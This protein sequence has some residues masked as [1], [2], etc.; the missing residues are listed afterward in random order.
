MISISDTAYPSLKARISHQDLLSCY[1]PTKDELDLALSETRT[2]ATQF[3]FL[4]TLKTLQHLGYVVLTK[5]IPD[6]II[7]HVCFLIGLDKRKIIFEEYD[8]STVRAIH[9]KI[10]FKFLNI[11]NYREGGKEVLQK[12]AWLAASTR[13]DLPSIV[14]A[15]LDTLIRKRFELP[16]FSSIVREAQKQRTAYYKEL[17]NTIFKSLDAHGKDSLAALFSISSPHKRSAW[18]ELKFE[19]PSPKPKAIRKLAK[20]IE[21]LSKWEEFDKILLGIPAVKLNQLAVEARALDVSGIRE[22]EEK[23]RFSLALVLVSN[24]R[25]RSLDTLIDLFLK[26]MSVIFHKS[27]A[28]LDK[29]LRENQD[30][31][32]AIL[33]K[34]IEVGDLL[35]GKEDPSSLV[36]TIK[37]IVNADEGLREYA[38]TH[39]E[40]G[41][42]HHI[43][44]MARSFSKKRGLIFRIL[45]TLEIQSG[46]HDN[47]LVHALD[48]LKS[49][50]R[51]RSQLIET[52][53]TKRARGQN[54]SPICDLSWVPDRWWKLITGDRN[55]THFPSH[56]H[57][58]HFEAC[59]CDQIAFAFRTGDLFVSG[60]D[61]YD[62]Y[63]KEL[64]P[65]TECE[66]TLSAYGE[67]VGLPVEGEMFVAFVKKSLMSKAQSTDDKKPENKSFTIKSGEA[68]LKPLGPR[69]RQQRNDEDDLLHERMS[70]HK[71]VDILTDTAQWLSWH[72]AF[73]PHSGHEGKIKDEMKRY[74][75]TVFA[76]G[77]GLGPT[78]G[79]R[80]LYDFTIH[81]LT[82]TDKHHISCDKLDRA[83][84]VV[85]AA[86]NKLALPRIW[87]EGKHVAAD[88]TH[89]S[90]TEH[91]A[92]GEK[93][94]RYGEWGAIAYYH[95]SDN[96]IAI[97][98]KFI[99]CGVHEAVYILDA[100]MAQECGSRPEF[101]HGDTHAQSAA[102]YGLSYLLGIKLMPRI[103][104]WQDLKM[105]K[106]SPELIY[107]H[108]E[109]LFSDEKP[110]W[111]LVNRHLPDMYQVAQSI[112]A[113]RIKPSTI[114]R[115]LGTANAKNKLF[116]A[117][118]ALGRI[119][120][121][122]YLL[123]YISDT[124][125]RHLIQTT[126]NRCE[127]FHKF[128]RWIH[129]AQDFIK[130]NKHDEQIKI[131]KYNHLIATLLTFHNAYAMTESLVGME[132]EGIVLPPEEV[133]SLSP[134]RT[135]H[136]QRFGEFKIEANEPKPMDFCLSPKIAE[137]LVKNQT[138]H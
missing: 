128:A 64:I 20:H 43:R 46:T 42:K 127:Q 18:D 44:F 2:L 124:E 57:R 60:S 113:G 86:Y 119:V 77:T 111:E 13:E 98:S 34:F 110:N 39:G 130:K 97:F 104:S 88:G 52:A 132:A 99:A 75:A 135:K 118:N 32:D 36:D 117:F 10:I 82:H 38:R 89:W 8:D 107:A 73:G 90:L 138:M 15:C 48:F 81:Q 102:A 25:G 103:R 16:A 125:L 21:W 120:R 87:G 17:Y 131:I 53:Q 95:V 83:I 51:S 84:S 133:S 96:Y 40:F 115:R 134:F 70:E 78:E 112:M 41:G 56:V 106:A 14:N 22:V 105:Y 3:G 55:R 6:Q 7:E 27:R 23:K 30:K 61:K 109:E 11:Q 37:T 126:T 122:I 12:A 54:N 100:V 91:N 94:L 66:Q 47:A 26:Q 33:R 69:T 136:I 114:L 9:I 59:L 67:L 49:H 5:D 63:R 24:Q 72:C 50:R 68:K 137:R 71:L 123:D 85:V 93:H 4:V 45:T 129:F 31:T 121:T 79:A 101:V 80:M 74:A 35:Q 1:T 62:D 58:K 76:Y 28:D 19:V 92:F 65:L 108:I 116:Q 29:Y